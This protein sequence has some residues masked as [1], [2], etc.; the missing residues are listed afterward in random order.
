ML[1]TALPS[2]MYEFSLF[3]IDTPPSKPPAA[4][5]ISTRQERITRERCNQHQ[6]ITALYNSPCSFGGLMSTPEFY[7]N[8]SIV[9]QINAPRDHYT[10]N[11]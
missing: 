6:S 5:N 9:L 7:F 3:L 2:P 1:E 4:D 8:I 11:D 10:I